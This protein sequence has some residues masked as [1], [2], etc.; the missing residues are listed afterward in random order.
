MPNLWAPTLHAAE[1]PKKKL[2]SFWKS[3]R[4]LEDPDLGS[5]VS[6]SHFYCELKQ[7]SAL[8]LRR[9]TLLHFWTSNLSI[10]L[11]KKTAT[12]HVHNFRICCTRPWL[13]KRILGDTKWLQMIWEN[14]GSFL[15]HILWGNQHVWK[16]WKG[17]ARQILMVR[18]VFFEN[19]E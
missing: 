5:G 9:T 14:P 12:L 13:P 1:R 19:L 15:E 10:S 3:K 4:I 6:G 11:W 2:M 17:G 7:N 8:N 18:P 16:C